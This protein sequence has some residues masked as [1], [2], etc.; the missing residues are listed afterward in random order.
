VG[1]LKRKRA[2][3]RVTARANSLAPALLGGLFDILVVGQLVEGG[4]DLFHE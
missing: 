1:V 3:T 4:L 2:V